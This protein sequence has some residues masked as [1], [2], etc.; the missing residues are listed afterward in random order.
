MA[1]HCVMGTLYVLT[2]KMAPEE[3]ADK[4][5]QVPLDVGDDVLL[6]VRPCRTMRGSW[7]AALAL[8]LASLEE[9]YGFCGTNAGSASTRLPGA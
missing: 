9:H 7:S 5:L 2:G 8:H 1:E 4:L 3:L 6:G